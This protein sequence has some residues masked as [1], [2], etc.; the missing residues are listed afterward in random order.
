[1]K[2]M[3]K[4]IKLKKDIKDKIQK[5]LKILIIIYLDI[6]AKLHWDGHKDLNKDYHDKSGIDVKGNIPDIISRQ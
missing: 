1:M 3:K 2:I 5:K 4:K 6:G